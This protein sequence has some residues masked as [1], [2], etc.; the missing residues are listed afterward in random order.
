MVS[1]AVRTLKKKKKKNRKRRRKRT[2]ARVRPHTHTHTHTRAHAREREREIDRQIERESRPVV[3]TYP[4]R[5]RF[6]GAFIVAALQP[7]QGGLPV[8][9]GEGPY[10]ARDQQRHLNQL[11]VASLA[12]SHFRHMN[13]RCG[14]KVIHSD[15]SHW[16]LSLAGAATC[17]I[18]VP[19]NVLSRQTRV[20]SDKHDFVATKRLSRQS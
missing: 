11:G 19:T 17:I 6:R 14:H 8:G 13:S 10:A 15:S 5:T 7:G 1:T 9:R 3:S 4:A 2:H 18:F 16:F 12:F 20:C